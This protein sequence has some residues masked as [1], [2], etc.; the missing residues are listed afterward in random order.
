MYV[1]VHDNH[2]WLEEALKSQQNCAVPFILVLCER[3]KYLVKTQWIHF[4][5]FTS[6]RKQSAKHSFFNENGL[7]LQ[8]T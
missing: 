4:E 2:V 6:F 1:S 5:K 3:R 8:N 7:V